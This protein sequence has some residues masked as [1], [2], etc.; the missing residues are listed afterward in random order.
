MCG[1]VVTSSDARANDREEPDK[2]R[3]WSVVKQLIRL[4]I[5][6][7]VAWGIWRAF[8]R[9]HQGF[10]DQE[11]SLRQVEV[12]WLIISGVC[13]L[14]GLAPCWIFWHRTLQAMGQHPRWRE[15]LRA[16]WIGHL[17]KYVPGKAMVV[18]LRTG[19]IH[20]ER[21]NRTVAATSVFVETLTMMA[22]GAFLSSVI[23]LCTSDHVALTLLAVALML[24]SGI[25]TVPPIFQRLVRLLR[26]HRA[27]PDIEQAI[28]GLNYRLMASGWVII[29]LGWVFLGLSLWATL[30]SFAAGELVMM[31]SLRD[32]PLL[33]ATVGLAMVA[34]FLSLIPGGLGV[35]DGILMTL[36]AP[37]YGAK[38]AVVSAILL[39]VVWLLSELVVSGIL[40]VDELLA[41]RRPGGGS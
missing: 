4:S 39:R 37:A 24:C 13:Y 11:F 33:T 9:A 30:R 21:V 14:A 2:P 17:G 10:A 36:L 7:A 15:S 32:V 26:V 22:V 28:S 20:S 29:T 16:F 6:A 31:D 34:G 5:L 19:L 27:N 41:R 25:P 18:V 35:R 3:W 1:I 40:Y 23:L 8:R 38:V 12:T